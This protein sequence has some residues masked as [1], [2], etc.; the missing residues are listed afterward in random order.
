VI[1]V[2]HRYLVT[3]YL[4]VKYKEGG[5]VEK[6]LGVCWALFLKQIESGI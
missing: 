6:H 1:W 3:H 4:D 2:S 5:N